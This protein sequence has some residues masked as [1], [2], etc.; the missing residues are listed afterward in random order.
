MEGGLMGMGVL[1]RGKTQSKSIALVADS[2][3]NYFIRQSLVTYIIRV[4][5]T[6]YRP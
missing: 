6:L 1:E 3:F 4:Y 2:I 5:I